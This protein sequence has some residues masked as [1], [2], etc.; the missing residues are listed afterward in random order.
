MVI[1]GIPQKSSVQ[2][3]LLNGN[4][5]KTL[6]QDEINEYQATWNGKND[7]DVYVSSGVYLVLIINK[8]HNSS[9]IK[10]IAVIKN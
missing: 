1:D 7:E 6:S 4:I 3:M 2:I 9:T 10:K 5:V 8:K